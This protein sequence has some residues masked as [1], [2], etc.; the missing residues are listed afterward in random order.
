M[1]KN[2]NECLLISLHHW[3]NERRRCNE[4]RPR[5]SRDSARR[6]ARD[7][8]GD[9]QQRRGSRFQVCADWNCRRKNLSHSNLNST[10]LHC[11]SSMPSPSFSG[12][13]QQRTLPLQSRQ[14]PMSVASVGRNSRRCQRSARFTKFNTSEFKLSVPF[15]CTRYQ[16]MTEIDRRSAA[17]QQQYNGQRGITNNGLTASPQGSPFARQVRFDLS[18][19]SNVQSCHHVLI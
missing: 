16:S 11:R 19:R 5:R 2:E 6:A 1:T 7:L 3:Q 8:A 17:M 12:S 10:T 13:N 9:V 18:F 14:S 4:S 15:S